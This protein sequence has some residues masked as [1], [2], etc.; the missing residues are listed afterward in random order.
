MISCGKIWKVRM[1]TKIE[2]KNKER[3]SNRVDERKEEK[4]QGERKGNKKVKDI[5]EKLEWK[6]K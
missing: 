6:Q 4:I 5:K 1:G 3:T 2:D